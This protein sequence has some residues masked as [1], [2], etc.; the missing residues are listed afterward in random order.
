MLLSRR[1]QGIG[2][3]GSRRGARSNALVARARASCQLLLMHSCGASAHALATAIAPMI[4]LLSDSARSIAQ[5]RCVMSAVAH[6]SAHA[7]NTAVAPMITLLSGSARMSAAALTARSCQGGF[8]ER[9]NS[10]MSEAH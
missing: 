9:Q 4:T 8:W 7:L 1:Q 6:A 5:A 10:I 3:V 2:C